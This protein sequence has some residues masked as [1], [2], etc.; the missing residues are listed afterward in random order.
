MAA[1]TEAGLLPEGQLTVSRPR[2]MDPTNLRTL[3]EFGAILTVMG[4]E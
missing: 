2:E 1:A 3:T 4:P